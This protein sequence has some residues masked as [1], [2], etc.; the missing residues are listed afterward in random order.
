MPLCSALLCS[1]SRRGL[2]LQLPIPTAQCISSQATVPAAQNLLR[3]LPIRLIPR[4]FRSTV[5]NSAIRWCYYVRMIVELLT[6]GPAY[7]CAEQI[8][9]WPTSSPPSSPTAWPSSPATTTT[10][11]LSWYASHADLAKCQASAVI[12]QTNF[13]LQKN[14][15]RQTNELWLEFVSA[16]AGVSNQA[17]LPQVPLPEIV[18]ATSTH[19]RLI[20]PTCPF[21]HFRFGR[22]VRLMVF[23]LE[24]AVACMSRFVDQFVLLFDASK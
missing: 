21:L 9:S 22:F 19:H 8:T 15:F 7:L 5:R 12:L 18:R 10:A 2:F 4:K 23:T 20:C 13:F 14:C 1:S 11:A 17:G 6:T 24:V 3:C 16:R